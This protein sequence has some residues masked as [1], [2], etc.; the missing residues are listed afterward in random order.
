M[1]PKRCPT[2]ARAEATGLRLVVFTDQYDEVTSFFRDGLRLAS[3]PVVTTD[4]ATSVIF[5]VGDAEIEVVSESRRLGAGLMLRLEVSDVASYGESL[6][7]C[8]RRTLGPI[9]LPWGERLSGVGGPGG[10]LINLVERLTPPPTTAPARV[11]DGPSLAVVS[12]VDIDLD[13]LAVLGLDAGDAHL[14]TNVGGV[15]TEDTIKD[16]MEARRGLGVERVTVV[17]HRP[18]AFLEPGP[19]PA[20]WP[21]DPIERLRASVSRLVRP[22]LSLAAGRV[23]GVLWEGE[24]HTTHVEPRQSHP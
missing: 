20:L 2:D 3:R 8:G 16:L 6:A 13:P 22:P 18:C 23:S 17:Q 15:V 21:P 12:C 11:E 10:L 4:R 1:S 5:T 7:A 19:L 9:D 24:G 14:I